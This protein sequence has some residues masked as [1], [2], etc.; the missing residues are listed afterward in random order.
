MLEYEPC[1]G[2]FAPQLHSVGWRLMFHQK[3]HWSVQSLK[4]IFLSYH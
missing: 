2:Y 3:V 1:D 4:L